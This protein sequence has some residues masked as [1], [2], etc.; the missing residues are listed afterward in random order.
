M[1]RKGKL[2]KRIKRAFFRSEI[3]KASGTQHLLTKLA[4][5]ARLRSQA[6][7]NLPQFS[8]LKR[9]EIDGV[10]NEF[11]EKAEILYIK[12]FPSFPEADLSDLATTVYF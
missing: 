10:T 12:F 7:K 2:I 3:Y 4:K 5:W 8:P 9:R 11:N 1:N 6:L